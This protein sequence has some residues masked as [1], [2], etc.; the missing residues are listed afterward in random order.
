MA[1][2]Q[3][4]LEHFRCLSEAKLEFDCQR[5]LIIGANAAGK[6][7]LLEAVYYLT[8]GRSFKSV[9]TGLLVQKGH[10]RFLLLGKT[11]YPLAHLGISGSKDGNEMH[12]DGKSTNSISEFARRFPAQVI[13]PDVHKLLEDGPARRRR[14][15]DWGVFHV[16]HSF[17]GIWQRFNRALKQRNAALKAKSGVA[18]IWELDIA[19]QG[20]ALSNLR[21]QYL[22]QLRPFVTQLGKQ[23]FKLELDFDFQQGW[24]RGS[25][26][27]DALA[28]SRQRDVLIG[29][30]TVGPHRADLVLRL[31]GAPAKDFVSRGQQ[32]LFA[33]VLVLAQQLHRIAI[34]APMACLLLD[35]PA[36]E[37]D[38]ENLRRLFDVVADLPVQLIVTA[39]SMS[40]L[41]FLKQAKLFHVEHGNVKAMA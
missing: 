19:L 40:G 36:A 9:S 8:A 14:Y 27:Q 25:Q 11:D 34:G 35:D 39:V 41:D 23:L 30:T 22:N 26:L 7:S 20:T 31:D 18:D 10:P 37:L 33:C 21:E 29:S 3:L 6:T 38:L 4:E 5:N 13:D 16:E 1:I 24:K 28:E 15:M 17:Q 32:K 12:V 2:I